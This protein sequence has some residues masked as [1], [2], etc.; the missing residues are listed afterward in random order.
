MG[1]KMHEDCKGAV[2]EMVLRNP[3]EFLYIKSVEKYIRCFCSH[4]LCP[5]PGVDADEKVS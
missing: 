1:T 2:R 5:I 3:L 4:D